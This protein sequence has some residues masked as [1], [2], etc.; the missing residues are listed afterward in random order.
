MINILIVT[1]GPLASALVET[2]NMIMGSDSN[3][4]TLSLLEGVDPEVYKE[5]VHK[6]IDDIY[7]ENGLIILADLYGGTPANIVLSKLFELGFPNDILTYSGVNLPLLLEV[8]AMSSNGTI[9]SIKNNIS[10]VKS[11]LICDITSKFKGNT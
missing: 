8:V 11:D 5:E 6:M 2:S 7:N 10:Q 9:E 1:H 3:I 4:S